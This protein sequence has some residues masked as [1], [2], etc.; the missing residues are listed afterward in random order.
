MTEYLVCYVARKRTSAGLPFVVTL[1]IQA[2][3]DADAKEKAFEALQADNYETFYC[4]LI[5]KIVDEYVEP[6]SL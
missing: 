1:R 3:D 5:H 4:S 6:A 2:T